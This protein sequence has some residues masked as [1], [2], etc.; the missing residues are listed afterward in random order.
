MCVCSLVEYR[1]E[2]QITFGVLFGV[3]GLSLVITLAANT[4][5]LCFAPN[6]ADNKASSGK[7]QLAVGG[8]C[9]NTS[10][11]RG[12]ASRALTATH[13]PPDRV[14]GGRVGV[15]GVALAFKQQTSLPQAS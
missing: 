3:M 12:G 5:V 7:W 6:A 2:L 9:L 10:S 4:Q 14:A 13:S 1:R 8:W 15:P 11:H